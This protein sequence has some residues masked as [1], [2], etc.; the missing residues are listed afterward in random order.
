MSKISNIL[1]AER[2]KKTSDLKLSK[3]L[4]L[5]NLQA[6]NYEITG[7]Y[8]LDEI[9]KKSY[10][11]E[12]QRKI[13]KFRATIYS[14]ECYYNNL[15]IQAE[16]EEEKDLFKDS[17]QTIRKANVSYDLIKWMV[18][19]KKY[20]PARNTCAY[21]AMKSMVK[22]LESYHYEFMQDFHRGN[23]GKIKNM[24]YADFMLDIWNLYIE[25]SNGREKDIR[26]DADKALE[27]SIGWSV[28]L[29][30][31]E[32]VLFL[33]INFPFRVILEVNTGYGVEIYKTSGYERVADGLGFIQLFYSP[34]FSVGH[35]VWKTGMHRNVNTAIK[36]Q[37]ISY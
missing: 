4:C 36:Y 7:E 14:V 8:Q 10:I 33:D 35:F 23:A 31:A 18:K 5:D 20:L 16:K 37:Y 9:L 13:E 34:E 3:S 12:W 32:F 29:N 1:I 27:D 6:H 22:C 24:R 26:K 21:D 15:I 28:Q 30:L 25:H 11:M 19:E 17:R 2:D